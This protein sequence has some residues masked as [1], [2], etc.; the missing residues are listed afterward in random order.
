MS[1]TF[2]G[3]STALNGLMSQ[4]AALNVTGQN[5][6]NA[7]TVGYTRQ[8]AELSAIAGPGRIGLIGGTPIDQIG[9]GVTVTGISRLADSF[10]DARQR[11]AHANVSYSTARSSALGQVESIIGEPS[12]TG[13]STQLTEF[14]NSWQGVAINPTSSPA[15]QSALSLATA[16]TTTLQR[17]A[18]ALDATYA[19]TRNQ[20]S[21]LAQEV[22]TTAAGVAN[23]NDRIMVIRAGGTDSNEL[24]D[25]RDQLVLK[26]SEL[27]GATASPAG[28]DGRV[29]VRVGGF[30]L[31][32]GSTAAALQVS[33]GS[34]LTTSATSPLTL[35]WSDGSTASVGSGE[36]GGVLDAL[37]TVY[38]AASAG[39]DDV[40][41][42]LITSANALHST[43]QDL[44]GVRTGDLFGGTGARDI[45]V[46]VQDP[47]KV[48]AAAWNGAA[49]P[50]PE[51][52]GKVADQL[53][54]LRS[55]QDGADSGWSA[56]VAST[57][58]LTASANSTLRVHAVI[59]DQ[60]DAGRNAESGVSLD[61]E[62]ANMLMFQR[63][64]EGAA[65]VM[66]AVD[67]M[68]DTLINRTGQVGR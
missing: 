37:R 66:T 57:G 7:N 16:V 15:R 17:G 32:T 68:L 63:A 19:D 1:S 56:F 29:D 25:Q 21:A 58:V 60:A 47:A 43:A 36:V 54:Q 9:S 65:R 41:K 4:R 67:E 40:A 22:N 61:E 6:A 45:R 10:V 42:R 59:S 55:A 23:L 18:A 64:Y 34:S 30:A 8:R 27:T 28:A 38:P 2:T 51:N 13:L 50:T 24:I 26:L 12:K 44:N 20:L 14:W 35:T 62:M 46:V 52:S 5:I 49:T 3:L 39:F 48:G 11:D 53:F 31:V 33:G